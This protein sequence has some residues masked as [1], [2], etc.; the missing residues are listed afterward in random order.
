[1]ATDAKNPEHWFDFAS[2]DLIRAYRRFA[3]GDY[4]DCLFH[5]QQSAEKVFKGNPRASEPTEAIDSPG[6]ASPCHS[7]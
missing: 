4:V 6:P 2:D 1:M 3:E 7:A 5:L